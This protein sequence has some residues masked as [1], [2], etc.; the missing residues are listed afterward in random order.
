LRSN[1][2][3]PHA[4]THFF[5]FGCSKFVQNSRR[6]TYDNNTVEL[7]KLRFSSRSH[8]LVRKLPILARLL[9]AMTALTIR[10]PDEETGGDAQEGKGQHKETLP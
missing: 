6:K 4:Q 5:V 9:I 2:V 8:A 7:L 3:A 1:A 10:R